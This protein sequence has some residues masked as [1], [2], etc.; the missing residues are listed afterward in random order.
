MAMGHV[1]AVNIHQQLLHS[2]DQSHTPKY[3]EFP[4]VPPMIALAVGKQAVLYGQE[5]GTTWG[6]DNM[7]MMFGE[8]LG[9]TICWNY[10]GLGKEFEE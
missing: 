6:E 1:A 5:E 10:L 8:D 4:E 2:R 3:S 9:W 7:K